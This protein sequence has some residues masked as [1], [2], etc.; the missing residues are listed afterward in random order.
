MNTSIGPKHILFQQLY[1][2]FFQP[3]VGLGFLI[4]KA[5]GM[6]AFAHVLGVYLYILLLILISCS[7]IITS[8]ACTYDI[9]FDHNS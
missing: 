9:R 5:S 1:V 7:G 3:F 2:F 4:V 6:S 8:C